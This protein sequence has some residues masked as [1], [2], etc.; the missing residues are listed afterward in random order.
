MESVKKNMCSARPYNLHSYII[1]TIHI[2]F[3]ATLYLLRNQS[4]AIT[5]S[6]LELNTNDQIRNK[7]TVHKSIK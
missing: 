3:G 2:G 1:N 6:Q 4:V 5:A 7:S